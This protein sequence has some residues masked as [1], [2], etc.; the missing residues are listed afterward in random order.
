MI[1]AG[2]TPVRAVIDRAASMV[3]VPTACFALVIMKRPDGG[4]ARPLLAVLAVGGAYLLT[5]VVNSG[6][7]ATMALARQSGFL[8][9][10]RTH[11]AVGAFF[12]LGALL[13]AVLL[14]NRLMHRTYPI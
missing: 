11:E 10:P 8:L 14:L 12:F 4:C 5:I 9:A 7:I 3:T 1:G 6:R 2:Y 13:V